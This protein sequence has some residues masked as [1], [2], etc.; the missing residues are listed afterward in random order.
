VKKLESCHSRL[1][2]FPTHFGRRDVASCTTLPPPSLF[3]LT[4][5]FKS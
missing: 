4:L 5:F 2:W 1:L 3:Q